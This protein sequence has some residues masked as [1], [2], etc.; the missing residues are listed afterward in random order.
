MVEDDYDYSVYHN[1][2][3][4]LKLASNGWILERSYEYCKHIHKDSWVFS[5]DSEDRCGGFTE[6]LKTLLE[7]LILG[8]DS[9]TESYIEFTVKH[10][11]ED[12]QNRETVQST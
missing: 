7:L 12:R 11:K 10:H 9:T 3:Y 2:E 1:E 5:N 8:K 4:S 6:V